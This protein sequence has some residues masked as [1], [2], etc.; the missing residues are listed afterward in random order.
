MLYART[1]LQFLHSWGVDGR[2]RDAV[3]R[4]SPIP[5]VMYFPRGF[6]TPERRLYIHAVRARPTAIFAF[7]GCGRV[8]ARRGGAGGRPDAARVPSTP[9]V[10]QAVAFRCPVAEIDARTLSGKWARALAAL[11]EA[12]L[13][14]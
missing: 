8:E 2:R 13:G 7:M 11:F 10:A 14:Q 12:E 5:Y 1:L 3:G 9:T 4:Y 6:V